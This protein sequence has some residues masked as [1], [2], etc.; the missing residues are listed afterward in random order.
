MDLRNRGVKIKIINGNKYA[1]DMISYWDKE[2]KKYRKKS[3]Y[4]GKV[5]DFEEKKYIP[6]NSKTN[7]PG[8]E[9]ILNFGD[10]YSI[11]KTVGNSVFDDCIK[12]ILPKNYDVLM[13]LVCY[14]LLKSSSMQ[15]AQTWANGNYVS[16]EYKNADLSSQRISDFLKKLGNENVWRR[17]FKSYIGKLIGDKTGVIIDSTGLPNEIDFPLS[18]WGNHGGESERETRLLMV[19]ERTSGHPLYFSYKAGNI[20]DVSTLSNTIAELSQLGVKTSFA[21]IDAGYYSKSNIEEL[22]ANEISFLTRLP[23]GRVL[24]KTLIE[25]HS[26]TL[27]DAKNLVIYGKRALYIK[28]V[29]VDLFGHK[30][31]AYIACDIKRKGNEITKF[32]IAAKEDNLSDDVINEKITEK[33]KFVIITSE[34]IPDDEILPLY[35]TRQS[36]ENLF[37]ISKSF[38]DIL[39]IRTHSIETFRGYLMLNFIA[40]I[41]YIEMKKLL[42]GEFTVEGAL[43]EMTN[44][45]CKVYQNEIIVCE[46][47]KKM[48][49]IAE[50]LN[51]MVP[52]FLGV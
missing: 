30:G 24:H 46:P 50:L 43:L 44:L 35:Y 25:E 1:Y 38:L 23:A 7:V 20:V 48:K 2:Q 39:P 42:R 6:K 18:A 19:V 47:T 13:S 33:G 45:M 49:R 21:L 29:E 31:F 8:T 41:V 51:Y 32:L 27:E 17:F 37:G 5:T 16:K 12:S 14:K 26:Q 9:L 10:S 28:C 34:K 36:A 52:K 4:L 11:A 3:V 22:F 15:Y 40:L